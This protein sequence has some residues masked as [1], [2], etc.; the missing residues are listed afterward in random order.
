MD[1]EDIKDFFVRFRG[2]IATLVLL[3]LCS[4]T[5][6]FLFET[7]S[8]NILKQEGDAMYKALKR[9]SEEGVTKDF[10]NIADGKGISARLAKFKL[11]E[12]YMLKKDVPAARKIYAELA[13][14]SGLVQELRELAEYLSVVLSVGSGE[15]EVATLEDKLIKLASSKEGAYKSSA[16]ETLVVLKL[17]NNDVDSAVKIMREI[18]GDASSN[19]DVRRNIESLLRVYGN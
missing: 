3:V 11:A 1:G 7:R 4:S 18:L 19:P 16:K 6:V 13:Q 15:G 5:A 12:S 10:T 17:K 8:E 9:V 14:D 2:T